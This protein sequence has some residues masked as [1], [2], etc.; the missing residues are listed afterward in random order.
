MAKK[1]EASGS[2]SPH[3]W[4]RYALP[5]MLLIA[6]AIVVGLLIYKT[7]AV[8]AAQPQNRELADAAAVAQQIAQQCAMGRQTEEQASVS[9]KL[10]QYLTGL[11][12]GAKVTT[13]DVGAIIDKITPSDQGLAF[14]K[15]YTDCLKQQAA[16]LLNQRG[17]TLVPPSEADLE[18]KK[19][20][21]LR[22]QISEINP[23]VPKTRLVQL[24]GEPISSGSNETTDMHGLT[25]DFYQYKHML[26]V[27][28]YYKDG[29]RV[30]LVIATK[31]PLLGAAM[32]PNQIR[33]VSLGE[34]ARIC[35]GVQFTTRGNARTNICP[36]AHATDYIKSVYFFD[37]VGQTGLTKDSRACHEAG[38]GI[39]R[40]DL[41]KCPGI[42]SAPAL[43]IAMAK[44]MTV[45]D[46]DFIAAASAWT[47]EMD[48]GGTFAWFSDEE[49]KKLDAKE[50]AEEKMSERQL[51]EAERQE[52]QRRA[53]LMKSPVTPSI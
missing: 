53:A 26:F 23:A 46:A 45:S 38:L 15:A 13:S 20:E 17:V 30:G 4:L 36:A 33:G 7:R 18:S 39:G 42:A 5:A 2:A 44:D 22:Q 28:D 19:D 11:D 50:A 29:R 41:G 51:A 37:S 32:F 35:E 34:A 43:G 1:R 16:I 49:S 48:F 24:L 21:Q 10:G 9:A 14:Y 6:V 12:A 3:G 31:D 40:M 25:A 8:P 52:R 27:A 47:D